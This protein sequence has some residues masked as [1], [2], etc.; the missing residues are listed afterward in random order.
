MGVAELEGESLGAASIRP[1]TL[2]FVVAV[3]V[4]CDMVI[5]MGVGAL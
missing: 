1:M 2:R 3:G 4:D 5:E